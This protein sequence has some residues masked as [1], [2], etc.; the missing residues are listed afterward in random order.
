ME[1][2][3][4]PYNLVFKLDDDANRTWTKHLLLIE[5]KIGSKEVRMHSFP[6]LDAHIKFYLQKNMHNLEA[7]SF[8]SLPTIKKA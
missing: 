1:L 7:C 3:G 2:V 6:S 8:Y 4:T 5:E